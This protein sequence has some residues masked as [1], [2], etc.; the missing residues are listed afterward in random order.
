MRALWHHVIYN[1]RYGVYVLDFLDQDYNAEQI[2]A[3]STF[4][5]QHIP[6]REPGQAGQTYTLLYWPEQTDTLATTGVV[7]LGFDLL[8]NDVFWGARDAGTLS[9]D[10]VDVDWFDNPLVGTGRHEAALSATGFSDWTTMIAQLAANASTQGLWVTNTAGGI[11]ITVAPGNQMFEASC[12]SPET[13]L[14]SGRYY[15]VSFFVTSTQMPG[16]PFGP[17]IRGAVASSQYV[18]SAARDL[19]GG[20]LLSAYYATPQP[21]QLWFEAPSPVPGTSVT[22]PMSLVFESWLTQNPE[23]FFFKEVQG[24]VHC[25]EVIAESWDPADPFFP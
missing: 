24:T 8:D 21:F 10:Q 16:G 20:G 15:R 5:G 25:H 12:A 23:M 7:Y 3:Y 4:A 11:S 6:G 2:V 9:C 19:R 17:T 22:E 13:T 18:Y 1:D 14:E